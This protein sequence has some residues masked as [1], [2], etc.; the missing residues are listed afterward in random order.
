MG[1][2]EKHIKELIEMTKKGWKNFSDDEILKL[3]DEICGI[4]YG[5]DGTY[6]GEQRQ[7]LKKESWLES[8]AIM[9][10]GVL[11]ERRE[12]RYRKN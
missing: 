8:L 12:G 9:Q 7:K 10:D 4:V 3:H 2:N 1:N 11:Y 6:T 5:G